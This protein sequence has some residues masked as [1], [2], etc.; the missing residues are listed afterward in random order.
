MKYRVYMTYNLPTDQGS[1]AA[2]KVLSSLLGEAGNAFQ[3]VYERCVGE[4]ELAEA[5]VLNEYTV[6]TILKTQL[7]NA[8][9]MRLEAVGVSLTRELMEGIAQVACLQYAFGT[10]VP[11]PD[12]A[13]YPPDG[14]PP[15]AA[16]VESA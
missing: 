8:T 14:G 16:D 6:R 12:D 3:P 1:V 10:A 15:T 2:R 9:G 4:I 11:A 5:P 13:E 7:P